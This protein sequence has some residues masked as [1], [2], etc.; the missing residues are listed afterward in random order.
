MLIPAF[1]AG[2]NFTAAKNQF[3]FTTLCKL[4]FNQILPPSFPFYL[5]DLKTYS[6]EEK[7]NDEG[8]MDSDQIKKE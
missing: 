6:S 3:I 8:L 2:R 4:I 5:N 7:K 1:L